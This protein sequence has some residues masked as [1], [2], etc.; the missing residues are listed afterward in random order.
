M[1][2]RDSHIM[3]FRV[4]PVSNANEITSHLLETQYIKLKL[5]QI[6]NAM[7]CETEF[8]SNSEIL[9]TILSSSGYAC[10]CNKQQQ[11]FIHDSFWNEYCWTTC[12]HFQLYVWNNYY[13]INSKP[14]HDLQHHPGIQFLNNSSFVHW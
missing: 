6:S 5:R 9:L 11:Q 10:E 7:V 1:C 12:I 3:A 14:V 2:I 4:V 8:E 13:W